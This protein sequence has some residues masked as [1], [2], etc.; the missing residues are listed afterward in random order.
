MFTSYDMGVAR[1][2]WPG[3]NGNYMDANLGMYSGGTWRFGTSSTVRQTE[4]FWVVECV[5]GGEFGDFH[6]DEEEASE[7][8]GIRF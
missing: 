8:D 4:K 5:T 1:V 3:A 2:Y 6:C 7:G